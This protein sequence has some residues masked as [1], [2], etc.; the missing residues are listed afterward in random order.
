MDI[1]EKLYNEAK[2]EYHPEQVSPFIDAHH[3]VC[4]IEAEDGR[5]FSGVCLRVI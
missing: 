1:W 4:A 5:I 2:K 3:V